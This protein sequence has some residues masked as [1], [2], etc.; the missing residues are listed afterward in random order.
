M[1]AILRKIDY[2][3]YFNDDQRP[4]PRPE[5]R[6]L[7]DRSHPLNYFDEIHF[8]DCFR[9]Y[10]N[11]AAEIIC[12]LQPKLS[13]DSVRGTPI[14]PFLQITLRFLACGTFHRETGDFCGVSESTVC[15]II[16]KVCNACE[17]KK[18]IKFPNTADPA[19]YKVEFYEY[20][21]FPG[22][23]GYIDGCYISIKCPSTADAEEFRNCKNWFSINV[24]GVCTA[25]MQFSNYRRVSPQ[26]TAVLHNYIK[27]HGC[28]DPHT[29]DDNNPQVPMAEEVKNGIPKVKALMELAI[30]IDD[31]L[32]ERRR[33]CRQLQRGGSMQS[34]RTRLTGE[35]RV[36]CMGKRKCT[37]FQSLQNYAFQGSLDHFVNVYLDDILV[38]SSSKEEHISHMR[39]VLQRLLQYRLYVKPEKCPS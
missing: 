18:I 2:L 9:M 30:C 5:R 1:R 23:I 36:K 6:L 26:T 33:Q 15:K 7:I 13:C 14:P 10:K 25:S 24:Q 19:T 20:G 31:R 29:E 28:P 8:C 35:E 27:Q 22:V 34:G 39:P 37:I 32:H 11:I 17:L 16:H 4:P 3:D 38:F 12:L 21:N